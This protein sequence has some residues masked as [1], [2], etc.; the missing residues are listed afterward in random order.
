MYSAAGII[1]AG[2]SSKRMGQDKALLPCP[3]NQQISFVERLATLLLS[4]CRE[5]ILVVRD[6]SQETTY[7]R[8][9]PSSVHVVID[10]VPDTGP[11]MGLYSGLCAMQSSHALVTAV[12]T[13]FL[14]YSLI[15][16]LLSEFID[17]QPVIP[18]VDN[19][20]QVLLAV[21]PRTMLPVIE[22]KLQAGRQDPRAL[23]QVAEIHF[24]E[25][26]QLRAVDPQLR[27]FVNINTPE[28]FVSCKTSFLP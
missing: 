23:L 24:L 8:H 1:L 2:G 20:P 26:E 3:D 12:D 11:L 28:D 22:A 27:S 10:R 13:P 19:F 14:Q 18:I 17:N 9:V 4:A 21:Y 6:M 5:V 15:S 16:F 25:E 7:A